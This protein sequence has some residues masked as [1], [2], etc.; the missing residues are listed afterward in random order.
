[1]DLGRPNTR[2]LLFS[3]MFWASLFFDSVELD[4]AKKVAQNNNRRKAIHN[5]IENL[6]VRVLAQEVSLP[7]LLLLRSS[8]RTNFR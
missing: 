1:M 5:G 7:H 4:T 3:T 6:L 2:K 8:R